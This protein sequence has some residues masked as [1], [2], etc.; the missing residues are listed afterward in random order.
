M[1]NIYVVIATGPNCKKRYMFHSSA[2]DLRCT[3]F[4]AYE[5]GYE[6]AEIYRAGTNEY[7]GTFKLN[8]VPMF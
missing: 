2:E 7:I 3:C 1:N 8:E 4:E 5:W 6:V